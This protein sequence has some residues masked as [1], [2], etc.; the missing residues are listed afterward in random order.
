MIPLSQAQAFRPRSG[1]STHQP[2][3]K[4]GRLTPTGRKGGTA[5]RPELQVA[6][7]HPPPRRNTRAGLSRFCFGINYPGMINDPEIL[8]DGTCSLFSR[9]D[10]R[11]SSANIFFH[12]K[13]Q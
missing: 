7:C 9:L 4:A 13:V 2:A 8:K 1:R 6:V 11:E 5:A 3:P 10:T 12:P